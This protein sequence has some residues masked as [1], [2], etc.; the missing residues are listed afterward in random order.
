MFRPPILFFLLI[1]PALSILPNR[2]P[3]LKSSFRL[4]VNNLRDIDTVS[5]V[6][7]GSTVGVWLPP[8]PGNNREEILKSIEELNPGGANAG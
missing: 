6:V 7:Y 8:T 3:L 2:L 1:F 5:I 4:L